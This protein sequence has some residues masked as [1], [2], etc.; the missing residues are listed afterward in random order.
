[1]HDD[2]THSPNL[3]ALVVL[4]MP[5][6]LAGWVFAGQVMPL[7]GIRKPQQQVGLPGAFGQSATPKGAG[8]LA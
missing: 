5:L 2:H 3:I 8:V 7:H 6:G 4:G 1:M